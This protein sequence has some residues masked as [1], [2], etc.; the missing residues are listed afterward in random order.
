[1]LQVR[2]SLWGR[3]NETYESMVSIDH[4]SKDFRG[5]PAL[6]DLTVSIMAGAT[7]LLGRNGAGKSTLMNLVS[8]VVLPSAGAVSVSGHAAG[9]A[10]AS[11]LVA[12]QLEFPGTA[13]FLTAVRLAS[14]LS[15]DS[16]EYEMLRVILER[17][18]VP[19]RSMRRLS[20]GNQLKL[21]LAVAFA[22]S[23]PILLLDEPTSGLD[24]F[25]VQVLSELI[26]ERRSRRLV[27]IVATHQPTLTPEL[28][29]RA[30]VVDQGS[31]LFE[32]D[33]AG[34]LRHSRTL[35]DEATPTA[36][37]STAMAEL[38]HGMGR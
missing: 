10:A 8:G 7:A 24:I 38:L 11:R 1:M 18:E 35:P 2:D 6:T 26:E 20:R 30:L 29:D 27:T 21:A 23:R 3:A 22:R 12:R 19:N 15:M 33:L 4:V 28:F 31:L 16:G 36:R 14:L 17:F 5:I 25:G 37:L 34:L 13:G 9:S 32:G